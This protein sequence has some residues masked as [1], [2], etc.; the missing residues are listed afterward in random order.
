M[1]TDPQPLSPLA[2]LQRLTPDPGLSWVV[3]YAV[4]CEDPQCEEE[5]K[6]LFIIPIIGW[7]QFG[8]YAEDPNVDDE[9]ILRPMVMLGTGLVTDYLDIPPSFRFIAVL[10]ASKDVS[11]IAHE[12]YSDLYGEAAAKK[13]TL[14]E[15]SRLPN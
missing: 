13:I 2:V 3:A 6:R 15:E 9:E 10:R 4:T 8:I 1:H 14:I 7:G 11:H 5:H 12:I